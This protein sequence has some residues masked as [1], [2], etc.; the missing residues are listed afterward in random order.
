MPMCASVRGIPSTWAAIYADGS[1]WLSSASSAVAESNPLIRIRSWIPPRNISLKANPPSFV[2][3]ENVPAKN[4]RARASLVARGCKP[5]LPGCTSPSAPR[6]FHAA[7][8]PPRVR[9]RLRLYVSTCVLAVLWR[10]LRNRVKCLMSV[11]PT[12]LLELSGG[13]IVS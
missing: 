9:V 3:T 12:S 10:G 7:M 5:S 2:E 13:N 11:M 1:S 6:P 8:R 4:H